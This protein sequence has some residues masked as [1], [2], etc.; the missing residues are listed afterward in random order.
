[1]NL[2][3][4][5][6]K[7]YRLPFLTAVICVTFEAVCDLLGPT[8]M[9][10]IINNGIEKSSWNAVMFWGGMMLLVTFI[11]ACFAVTRNFLSSYVSQKTG[12]EL[13]CDLFSKI[14]SFSEKDTD[15]I[16]SGSLITRMTNDTSQL[17]QFVN[18][19]M[20]IF[21]KAPITCIGSIILAS[22]LNFRL[23][24]IIYISVLLVSLLLYFSM[25]VS[26][27]RFYRLQQAI[28]EMNIRVQEYLIGIRLVKAFGTYEKETDKFERVNQNLTQKNVSSQI[29]I[30]FISPILSLIIGIGTI[31]IIYIGGMLFQVRLADMGDMTAFTIYMA[32]ILSSLIMI[33]NVFTMFVRTKAS[34]AR[35]E[36]ILHAEGDFPRNTQN[37]IISGEITF[38]HVT[39][40]Y[41]HGSG[42]PVLKDLSFQIKQGESIAVIGPTGSGKSTLA[43]LL[44]RFYD[45]QQ[46]QIR[47]GQF[48]LRDLGV[49]EIRE[50][51]AIVPQ[52]ALLFSGTIA[53]NIRWG[54]KDASQKMMEQTLKEAEAGFVSEMP[55]Q[56][57]S[58][59]GS[60]GVNL[61]GGQK[62]RISLAR[63][64]IKKSGILILDDSLSALDAITEAKV[65][66]HLKE[67]QQRQTKIIITQRCGT[68]MTA[69]RIL[70]LDQGEK[71]GMGTHEELMRGCSI[72]QDLYR[73]QM[74]SSKEA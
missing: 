23:S 59:I 39:F 22:M 38:D 40:T 70:V 34:G 43:S 15:Q 32:Q 41:P 67:R 52:K 66:K 35:I 7:K 68:A 57:D 1:L 5:Y 10:H 31:M 72:Y 30:T 45:V 19:I 25:H 62:Q 36:E 18:G 33:T 12:A 64:L 8:L 14:M 46:G 74:E 27:P 2:F 54:K 51:V 28:D 71:A 53:D 44:L 20:R 6:L 9:S 11:G 48:D 60:N 58:M 56:T 4:G 65:L 3:T 47:L 17:I 29:V 73:T 42:I 24:L 50:Q 26:Y 61:S 63:G 13:R 69:D 49:N 55:W 37:R 16:Q 21:L